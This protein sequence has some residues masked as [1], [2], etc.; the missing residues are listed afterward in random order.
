MKLKIVNKKKFTRM[1]VIL[2]IIII[3]LFIGLNNTYSKGETKYKEEYIVNGDTLWSIAKKEA[4]NNKYYE[5]KDI[6]EIVQEIKNIN[7]LGNQNLEIGQKIY[8]PII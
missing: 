6:R 3:A 8:I 5:E 2:G 1:L 7:N 4:N